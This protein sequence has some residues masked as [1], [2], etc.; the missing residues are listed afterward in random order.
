VG[1]TGGEGVNVLGNSGFVAGD[2]GTLLQLDKYIKR[3]V[4]MLKRPNL[5]IPNSL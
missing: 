5:F 1:E 2:D 3:N 4:R